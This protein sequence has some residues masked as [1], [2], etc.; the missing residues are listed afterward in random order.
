MGACFGIPRQRV[1]TENSINALNQAIADLRKEIDQNKDGFVTKDELLKVVDS[2]KDGLVSMKELDTFVN[3]RLV[4]LRKSLKEREDEITKLNNKIQ[5]LQKTNTQ[6]KTLLQEKEN[7][8]N[9]ISSNLVLKTQDV[10]NLNETI[11]TFDIKDGRLV[12][13]SH[14]VVYNYIDGLMKDSAHNIKGFPDVLEKP[15]KT[16]V[17]C[18]LLDI[19]KKSIKGASIEW[20]DHV[21]GISIIPKEGL[22]VVEHKNK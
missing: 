20:A 1:V 16:Y 11:Q 21:V 5:E 8:L 15:I 18:M 12:D 2:N 19:I 4:D 13:V 3:E 17:T 9:N 7:E 14:E 22:T 6:Q 10:N